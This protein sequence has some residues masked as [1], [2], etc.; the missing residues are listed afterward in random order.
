[1]VAILENPEIRRLVYKI[2]VPEYEQLGESADGTRT[3]LIRGVVIEEMAPSPPHSFLITRLQRWVLAAVGTTLYCRQEQ[4]LKLSDSMP[5][6]DLAVIDGPEEDYFDKHPTSAL[7]VMEVAV[8][9]TGLDR[10]KASLYAEAG[11]REYWIVLVGQKAVEIYSS[12]EAGEYTHRQVYR[13]GDVLAS[14]VLPAL[15]VEV[16]ALFAR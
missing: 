14:T 12:P 5:Q 3:E 11:I 13:S 16:E 10:E 15:R 6:P 9:S 7:W 2:S 8:S 4:P 1:M